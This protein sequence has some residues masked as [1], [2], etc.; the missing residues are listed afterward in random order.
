[1]IPPIHHIHSPPSVPSPDILTPFLC[2]ALDL[3]K[4]TLQCLQRAALCS[5]ADL[6]FKPATSS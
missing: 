1:M 5:Q 4:S 2:R 6:K 3:L